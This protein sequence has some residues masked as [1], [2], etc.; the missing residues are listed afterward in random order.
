MIGEVFLIQGRY[1]DA[2]KYE[3]IYLKVAKQEKDMVEMQRAYVY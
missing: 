2:L 3:E 1:Q